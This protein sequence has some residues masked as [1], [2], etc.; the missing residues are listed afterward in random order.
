[1]AVTV[2]LGAEQAAVSAG[3]AADNLICAAYFTTLYALARSIP[4]EPD[5]A[6][7]REGEDH[8]EVEV[9]AFCHTEITALA[10]EP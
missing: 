3:L 6:Q 1:M 5:P 10:R 7:E 9:C 4:R 2:G 8:V